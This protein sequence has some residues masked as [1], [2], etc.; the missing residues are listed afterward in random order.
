ME[1]I[2]GTLNAVQLMGW[3]G[4]D[5]E[6]RFSLSGTAIC[7]FRVATKRYAGRNEDGSRQYETEWMTIETWDRL[8]ERCHH[9]LRKG[10]RVL[11]HGGIRTKTWEDKDSGQRRM[12]VFVHADS[13]AFLDA[14]QD[15]KDAA[16]S[17][18]VAL[19]EDVPF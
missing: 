4:A 8:A 13:V 12:R 14:R 9:E 3:L 17:E 10:S 15:E 2:K 16:P 6:L 19:A 5:P 1:L 18:T 11:I 7:Q